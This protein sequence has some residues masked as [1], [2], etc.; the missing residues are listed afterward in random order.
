[1]K[2]EFLDLPEW[3]FDIDEVSAGVYQVAATDRTGQRMSKTGVDPEALIEE[4][5]NEVRK[6]EK[7]G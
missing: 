4:C 6:L 3:S 2:R 5:R 7:N 1:M